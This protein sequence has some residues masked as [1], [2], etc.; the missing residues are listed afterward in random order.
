MTDLY[1]SA[2]YYIYKLSSKYQNFQGWRDD[3]VVKTLAV[4]PEDLGLIPSPHTVYHNY[5]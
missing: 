5:L 4:L 2:Y 1:D 3:S